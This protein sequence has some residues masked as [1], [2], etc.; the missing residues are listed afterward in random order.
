[1]ADEE[2]RSL[3]VAYPQI[4]VEKPDDDEC[5]WHHR[6][7]MCRVEGSI[8]IAADPDLNLTRVDLSEVDHTMVGRNTLFPQHMLEEDAG[9]YCF[10]P[11][12]DVVLRRLYRDARLQASLFG[13]DAMEEAEGQE[14]LFSDYFEGKLGQLVDPRVVEDPLLFVSLHGH[15]IALVGGTAY[16]CESVGTKDKEKWRLEQTASSQDERV[17]YGDSAKE[18][19]MADYVA[20]CNKNI[21]EHDAWKFPG[22]LATFEWLQGVG[23]GPGNLLS[24]H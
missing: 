8:W 4:C 21:G 22:P 6:L 5:F 16:R 14:W 7:L 12:G 11:I 13:G 24:Y 3:D 9:L 2:F 10:D 18:L 23:D 1:M 17:F 20:A 19:G 15:G